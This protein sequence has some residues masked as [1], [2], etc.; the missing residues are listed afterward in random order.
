MESRSNSTENQVYFDPMMHNVAF[1]LVV[2]ILT[3]ITIAIFCTIYKISV[4]EER[5]LRIQLQQI[6]E[7]RM[8]A[9]HNSLNV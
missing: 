8:V 6:K 7:Q 9:P 4:G 3:L 5:E 2:M 1:G